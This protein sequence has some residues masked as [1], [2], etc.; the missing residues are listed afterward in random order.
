[1]NNNHSFNVAHIEPY[2]HIYGPGTRFVVWL[3]GCT[4][5]CKGCWNTEMWSHKSK[6][7]ISRKQLLKKIITTTDIQGVTILGGEPFQQ[8]ENVI[9]LLKQL[10][11]QSQLNSIV[12][13]G[14]TKDELI[15]KGIWNDICIN[16][17]LVITGRFEEKSQDTSLYLRGSANQKL[18]YTSNSKLKNDPVNGNEIEII[19]D[20]FARQ[21]VI[22][23][24]D[25]D[26]PL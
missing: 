26:S 13:S 23:Y 14:F 24:P 10:R 8:A 15:V 25:L 18:I 1:M 7:L 19:I 9:W 17:D 22:G 20:E 11:L 12:Y 6:Y 2:S 3:Q 21:T 4:L 16:T 5:G